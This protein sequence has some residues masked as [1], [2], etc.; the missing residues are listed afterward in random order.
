MNSNHTIPEYW[1]FEEF[2]CR[3]YIQYHVEQMIAQRKLKKVNIMAF[4][5]SISS[6]ILA[7]AIWQDYQNKHAES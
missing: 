3:L 4:I 2:W 7:L 1:P 5:I 6:T